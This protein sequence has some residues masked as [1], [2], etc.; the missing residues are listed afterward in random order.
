MFKS[1]FAKECSK[2]S[3]NLTETTELNDKDEGAPAPDDSNWLPHE[4]FREILERRDQSFSRSSS[5]SHLAIS[6]PLSKRHS[7][8]VSRSR[9]QTIVPLPQNIVTSSK[10]EWETRDNDRD[11]MTRLEVENY[12]LK[13]Q[14]EMIAK[15]DLLDNKYSKLA[16][17]V[18][19]LQN[20]VTQVIIV[21]YM[22]NFTVVSYLDGGV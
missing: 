11:E 12:Q 3:E 16:N 13:K 9:L 20:S 1:E 18:V 6:S 19:R 15:N 2:S 22:L 21:V 17:E 8:H 7:S 4:R 5:T 10:S 14:I